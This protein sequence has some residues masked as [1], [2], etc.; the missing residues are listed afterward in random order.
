[1]ENLNQELNAEQLALASILGE[2]GLDEDEIVVKADEVAPELD[3]ESAVAEVEQ[4][5]ALAAAYEQAAE[6]AAVTPVNTDELFDPSAGVIDPAMLLGTPTETVEPKKTKGKKAAPK[7]AAP[8]KTAEKKEKKVEPKPE[9]K[10]EEKKKPEPRKHYASKVERLNDRMG[11]KLNEY[12]CL[13]LDD[14]ETE[15]AEL[16]DRLNKTMKE[17]GVKVQNRMTFFIEFVS[18]RSAHLNSVCA[19]A[20]RVLFAEGKITTGDKGNLH[21]KLLGRYSV[22]SA[23]AMGG[24]TI[25]AMQK[26]KMV[27]GEKGNW[28]LNPDSLYLMKLKGMLAIPEAA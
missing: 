22:A 11:E 14:A 2:L 8:K 19:D 18:G 16:R 17:A 28:I 13:E 20:V 26:L 27:V 6:N 15:V 24:N 21:Q 23:K 9:V 25:L 10:V 12:A 4:T 5:E 7:K 3:I 1:M